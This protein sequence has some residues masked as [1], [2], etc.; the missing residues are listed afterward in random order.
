M[1][2][3]M[4]LNKDVFFGD[5]SLN[6]LICPSNEI[7]HTSFVRS[8]YFFPLWIWFTVSDGFSSILMEKTILLAAIERIFQLVGNNPWLAF[9]E[10][11]MRNEALVKVLLHYYN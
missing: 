9:L 3:I 8:K 6:A 2:R 4:D 5:D 7:H 11:Q 1:S 10:G